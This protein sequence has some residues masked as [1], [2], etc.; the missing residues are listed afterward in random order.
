MK[1][2]IL[3][4]IL[5]AIFFT[6]CSE[7]L[8]C[9]AP[10]KT[11]ATFYGTIGKL[12]TRATDTSWENADA[13]GIYALNKGQ[14]L[15]E[16]GIY[17][18]KSN[19]KYTTS[20][21]GIFKPATT[22]I[23]FPEQSMLDFIAYYPYKEN[24]A[25][26]SYAIDVTT[27]TPQS[28]IDLLYSNNTK[29]I[30][31]STPEVKLHFKHVLSKLVLALKTGDGVPS[32]EGLKLTVDN[33]LTNGTFNLANGTITNGNTKK[34][35]TPVINIAS[36]N[37]EA[38]ITAILL[39]GQDLKELKFTFTLNGKVY[40]WK[41]T[42][43]MLKSTTKYTYP[44]SLSSDQVITLK[45]NGTIE[46]WTEGNPGGT[47]VTLTP[48]ENPVFVADK[49]AITLEASTT[50][51][52]LIK[53]TTQTNQNWT[54]TSNQTWLTVTP[55]NGT[56]SAEVKATATENTESANRTAQ[57][58]ITATSGSF[59]P[60]TVTVTQKGKTATPTPPTTSAKLLFPGSDFEDWA[61]FTGA[62]NKYGVKNYAT[63]SANGRNGTKALHIKG[64][65]TRNDY[66]FTATVPEGFAIPKKISFYVKG[67]STK[68]IS[69]NVYKADKSYYKFN[70]EDC[71]QDKTLT[72]SARN[73]YTGNINT[74]NQWVKVTLDLS[75]LTDITTTKGENLFGFKV[76]RDVAWDVL[77]D[78][79][80][81]E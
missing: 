21:D 69:L 28:A 60:I 46:D 23:D 45:P 22:G 37:K 49:N 78:D 75:G 40:E 43:Q 1:N 39:P 35:I 13:I 33:A 34:T 71:T 5:G 3:V 73:G 31:K 68:S 17:S 61:A 65:P 62:L 11:Q 55:A 38:T 41:P 76:G 20:G 52:N 57:V 53:L 51:S 80:T 50:L 42:T 26:F 4:F 7:G 70:L 6:S 29:S 74:N 79:I 8:D 12:K 10:L 56:G 58:T 81:I 48:N 25:N 9:P 44:L 54:A 19:I 24:I 32:L 2:K 72:P 36:T 63:Q 27:Q 47:T 67:T 15:S 66:V 77:I 64:T 14:T 30:G 16:Q 59:A 18:G